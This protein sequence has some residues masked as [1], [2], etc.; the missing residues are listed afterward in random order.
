MSARISF[1]Q[2]SEDA[3]NTIEVAA[4]EQSETGPPCACI[5]VSQGGE[6]GYLIV[7]SPIALRAIAEAINRA[8]DHIEDLAEE[9]GQA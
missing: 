9:G 2:Y 1:L 6:G 3:H 4:R 8:A 5:S 7:D